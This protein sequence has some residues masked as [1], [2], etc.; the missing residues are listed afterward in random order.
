VHVQLVRSVDPCADDA[1]AGHSSHAPAPVS[2]LKVPA[3]HAAHVPPF[4]PVKPVLHVQ[5]DS[6]TLASA[7][8]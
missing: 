5:S 3:G 7:E 8:I 4:A 1:N 6:A 2:F